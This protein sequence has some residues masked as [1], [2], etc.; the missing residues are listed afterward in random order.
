MQ[1]T[2]G[3]IPRHDVQRVDGLSD[4]DTQTWSVYVEGLTL[5]GS[6]TSRGLVLVLVGLLSALPPP[7]HRVQQ[8]TLLQSC[9]LLS[10]P[11]GVLLVRIKPFGSWGSHQVA[12]CYELRCAAE[13]RV[14]IADFDSDAMG[15]SSAR[16]G[17]GTDQNGGPGR[18]IKEP[19]V[20]EW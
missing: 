11:R 4:Q 16:L 1:D 9:G 2:C 7:L 14:V 6:K 13:A 18:T 19:G 10:A 5:A 12:P 8:L 17:L 15:S 20:D 3:R